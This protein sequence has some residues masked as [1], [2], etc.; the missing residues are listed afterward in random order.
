YS[1]SPIGFLIST[2][3]GIAIFPVDA[4]DRETLLNQADTALYQ[5]KA[6]GRNTYRFFEAKM[7]AQAR[8][9]RL[10]EHDLRNALQRNE[11]R[12]VY[13]PQIRMDTGAI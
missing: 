9:R 1:N 3:I 12:L 8:E 6:E 10:I 7:G 4:T 13:Q 2:S 11:L 5:A